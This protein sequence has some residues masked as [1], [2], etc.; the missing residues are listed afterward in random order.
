MIR[1]TQNVWC[2]NVDGEGERA[3]TAHPQ[4]VEDDRKRA[5]PGEELQAALA[6]K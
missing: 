6:A 3:K 4:S 2:V 5:P 1:S